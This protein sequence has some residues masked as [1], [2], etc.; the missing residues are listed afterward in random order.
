MLHTASTFHVYNA[1]AGSGKTFTLVKEYLKILLTSEDIFS[2]QRVL[3]ITFTNKAATEMKE[4][5]L[6]GL[7][8]FSEGEIPVL[9]ELIEQE[10]GLERAVLQKRSRSILEAILQNYTAFNITT[11]DSFTYRVIKSF[12]FDLGLS[13][14]FEVEMDAQ[15]ILSQAV[16]LL[17]AKIGSDGELT[18]L[19][20]DYSLEKSDN[21]TSWNIVHDLTEF[22]RVLLNEDD[23]RYFKQLSEKSI[24]DFQAISKKVKKA[25][26]ET[27]CRFKKMGEKGLQIIADK[28]LNHSDFMYNGE[29]PKHF[30]KLTKL[31]FLKTADLRFEGRLNASFEND[32]HLHN[33]KASEKTK[34]EIASV[35]DELKLLYLESKK[36]YNDVFKEYLKGKLL[37]QS[38]VPLAVLN[39]INQE[40]NSIKTDQNL[41]FHSEFNQLISEEIQNQPAPFIYERIGQKFMHFFID[42]MQDT[43]ILQWQNLIPLIGNALS[44]EHT[45]LL[46]VGDGK[47]AIYRWRGGKAEQFIGLGSD[48]DESV[49]PFLIPKEV[50]ALETNYRSYS[51]IIKFNN[52]L[53]LHVSKFIHEPTYKALFHQKSFQKENEKKGGHVSISFLK[54]EEETADANIYARKVLEIIQH[55]DDGYDL[56]DVCVLVRKKKEGIAVA[57]LLSEN[58]IEIASSETLLLANSSKV[59]FLINFMRYILFSND[60]ESLFNVLC[61]LYDFLEVTEEKHLFFE[62]Y[63][64]LDI[65]DFVEEIEQL[66]CIFDL[67]EY[68]QLPLY[69][70]AEQ[71]IRSFQLQETP[72]AYVQFFLDEVLTQQK[73]E[74]DVQDILD[75]WNEKKNQLSV[76]SPENKNALRIM[77]IHKSK[78]LEFPIVIFPCDLDIYKEIKPKVWLKA[79]EN[80]PEFMVN[81][82]KDLPLTGEEGQFLYQTRREALELDNFNLLYVAMTR[83]VEQLFVVTQKKLDRYGKENP[84]FYSGIFIS[85]LKEKGL[86]RDHQHEY[87]FGNPHRLSKKRVL[88]QKSSQTSRFISSS[89]KHHHINLLASSSAL[90]GTSRGEAIRY[91]DLIHEM[92]SKIYTHEDLDQVIDSYE[93][94]GRFEYMNK[95]TITSLIKEIIYN[96]KLAPYFSGNGIVY[97]EREIINA[98]GQSIIPDRLVVGDHK[99]VTIID[100]KT[101]RMLETHK[102]QVE[103]YAHALEGLNYCVDKKILVYMNDVIL[104][105]EI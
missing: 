63:V 47:Q 15:S 39:H 37:L 97:N 84:Q 26:Y 29:C 38:I 50:L 94:S 48:N 62:K 45:S 4:R 3:A 16:E 95:T 53:F 30:I 61:F 25:M 9:G 41:R 66:G 14:N 104:V 2:F 44:Q 64:H 88:S 103:K 11:I 56:N 57:H 86:W 21:D 19:L 40:L 36:Y 79:V 72:D 8:G 77:T 80:F 98:S 74:A 22:S 24:S 10:T 6:E 27:E 58:D 46:L 54:K 20:I 42:E 59:N 34:D 32:R 78:G 82:N 52:E 43:S 68:H 87:T 67:L 60:R 28:G 85:F 33:S 65:Y 75:F 70:K 93:S 35:Y 102:R 23:A 49:N 89:W 69:E 83:A 51:E 99:K 100:Y 91:G 17:V 71:I 7:K 105:E 13:H 73:K 12:A 55:L 1:S 18:R 90:W 31:R 92:M 96:E 101:G 76:V 5:V 81:F